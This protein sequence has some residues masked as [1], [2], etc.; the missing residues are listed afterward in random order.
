MSKSNYNIDALLNPSVIEKQGHVL[1]AERLKILLELVKFKITILVSFSTALGYFLAANALD[2]TFLFPVIGIFLLA[3]S[4][5]ALNHYQER[6]TDALMNRTKHRPIPSGR[7][8]ANTVLIISA[9][10]FTAGSLLLILKTNL[11]TLSIG[12]ITFLWYNGL[13]TPLKRKTA[14]AIIPGALVGAL[15]PLA[16]WAAA[17][18]SLFDSRI[19]IIAFYFFVWQIPHF[20][21]LLIIYG[22]DYQRG[23]Y[24][25]LNTMFT[26][27]QLKRITFVWLFATVVIAML[28]PMFGIINYVVTNVILSAD[29]VWMLYNSFKFVKSNGENKQIV[30]TFIKINFYTLLLITILSVDKIITSI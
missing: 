30:N 18:G 6:D 4:A 11:I 3:C 21:L 9:I 25:T 7:I 26:R 17:D 28:I 12:L 1:W 2:F 5:S 22:D 24:P 19:L 23:G 27:E 13:Y 8:N 29:S 16:G 14:F 20:W 10:I 15:P